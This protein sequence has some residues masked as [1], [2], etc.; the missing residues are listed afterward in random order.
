MSLLVG[1]ASM[2][3]GHSAGTISFQLGFD[4]GIHGT[5]Y[6][7]KYNGTTVD[8]DTSGAGTTLFQF[9][10]QYNILKW[11]SAGFSFHGGSYIEDPD[12]AEADG[13]KIS[14]FAFDLRFYP[15]NKDKFTWYL[16][17]NYGAAKLEIN[18]RY[19][20]IT[21]FP[22]QYRFKGP[23]MRILTGFNFYFSKNVGLNLGLAYSTHNFKMT[24]YTVNN[25]PFDLT[26]YDN[27]LITRGA[28]ISLGLSLRFN[29]K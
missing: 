13:N 12:N 14:T 21:T 25:N 27:H 26:N 28:H 9:N 18:R 10:A 5:V 15:V 2:A 24:E 1:H 8:Q 29:N 23:D 16:G 22:V 11:L 4:A 3:Q 17:F 7:A 20:I 6:E 19:T